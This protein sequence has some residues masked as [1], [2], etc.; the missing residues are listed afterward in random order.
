MGVPRDS[1]A[2]LSYPKTIEMHTSVRHYAK[3]RSLCSG[4]DRDALQQD[5]DRQLPQQVAH[6]F[7]LIALNMELCRREFT[8]KTLEDLGVETSSDLGQTAP[9]LERSMRSSSSNR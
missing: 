8:P 6:L 2:K 1:R 3:L 9:H 4:P 5:A 7:Y